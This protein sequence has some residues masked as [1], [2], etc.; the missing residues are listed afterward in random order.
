RSAAAA[1]ARL[2]G[3]LVVAK[4]VPVDGR[5]GALTTINGLPWLAAT[6]VVAKAPR[7]AG[8]LFAALFFGHF[9]SGKLTAQALDLAARGVYPVPANRDGAPEMTLLAE[10]D[11]LVSP[12]QPAGYSL[13]P[14]ELR[15]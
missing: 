9:V 12:P 13:G 4:S 11:A 2:P 7:G 6:P 3:P 10:K 1:A 15:E 14:A 8:D 5:L